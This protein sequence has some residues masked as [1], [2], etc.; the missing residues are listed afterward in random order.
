MSACDVARACGNLQ[1]YA[2]AEIVFPDDP[3]L[4]HI[5]KLQPRQLTLIETLLKEARRRQS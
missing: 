1:S 3:A 2:L 4:L 5:E